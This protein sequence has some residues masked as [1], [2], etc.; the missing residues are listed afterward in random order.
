MKVDGIPLFIGASGKLGNILVK[1]YPGG[2][3][4]TAIPDM[5]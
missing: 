1:Q 3:V 5:S 4:I 2:P